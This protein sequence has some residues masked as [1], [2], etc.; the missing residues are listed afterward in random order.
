[1]INNTYASVEV[2]EMSDMISLLINLAK[3]SS[4]HEQTIILDNLDEGITVEMKWIQQRYKKMAPDEWMCPV[5]REVF[6]YKDDILLFSK[7]TDEGPFSGDE[8]RNMIAFIESLVE[9]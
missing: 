3:T 8:M 4:G 7:L 1:M 6:V 5:M 9:E 2:Y